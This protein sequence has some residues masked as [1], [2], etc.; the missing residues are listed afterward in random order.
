MKIKSL[1]FIGLLIPFFANTQN[2]SFDDD[3]SHLLKGFIQCDKTFFSDL[4]QKKYRNYFPIVNLPNG[5][6]KF[7]T[8]SINHPQKNRLTFDPPIIF[9][10]LKIE[11]F[12]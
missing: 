9:N 8:K 3:F 7:A 5:Y 2:S 6:S 11:S 12:E 4:N 1:F 10:G